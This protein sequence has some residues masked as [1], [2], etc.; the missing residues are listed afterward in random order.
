MGYLTNKFQGVYRLKCPYDLETNL[1]PRKL[2]GTLEDIDVYIDCKHDIQVTYY[3]SGILEAYIP[4]LIRGR[5]IV[6]EIKNK[7]G[8]NHI[9]ELRENDKE[10]IFKFRTS[11]SDDIIPMLSPKTSGADISPFSTRNLPKDKSYTIP[12][13]DLAEYKNAIKN[14]PKEQLLTITHTTNKFLKSLESKKRTR[15]NIKSDMLKKGLK[16]KEYIHS[17]GLWSEYIEFLEKDLC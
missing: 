6:S 7:F 3:G 15:E 12:D 8:E 14:V 9:L 10:I 16:G 11:Y 1:Y 2:D 17:I 4:S 13:E 5:R